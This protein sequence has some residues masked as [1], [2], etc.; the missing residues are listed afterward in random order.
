MGE[1]TPNGLTF[2]DCLERAKDSLIKY[3]QREIAALEEAKA[4]KLSANANTARR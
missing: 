3:R 4:A 2:N 1:F